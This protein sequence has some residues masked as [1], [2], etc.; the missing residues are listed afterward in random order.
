MGSVILKYPYI[1]M[2]KLKYSE[3]IPYNLRHNNP[4]NLCHN[5]NGNFHQ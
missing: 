1:R 3:T 4:Y 2:Y 5:D